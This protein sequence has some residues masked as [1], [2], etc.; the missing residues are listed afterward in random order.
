MDLLV[1]LKNTMQHDYTNDFW[2]GFIV[3]ASFV[4]VACGLRCFAKYG[5]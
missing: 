4:T 1:E 5:I 2:A 3:G